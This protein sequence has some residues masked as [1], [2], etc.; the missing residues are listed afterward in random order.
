[1]YSNRMK[2]NG[3]GGVAESLNDV[4]LPDLSFI[5]VG[6]E[7]ITMNFISIFSGQG[8]GVGAFRAA[9]PPS[10]SGRGAGKAAAPPFGSGGGGGGKER[11]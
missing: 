4:Y 9:V 2:G 6:P 10:G 1:M 3:G 7:K 11:V 8:W 5:D